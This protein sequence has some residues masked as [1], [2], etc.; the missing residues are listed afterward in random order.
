VNGDDPGS[1]S[2]PGPADWGK[3][4]KRP[5]GKKREAPRSNAAGNGW[6]KERAGRGGGGP[7]NVPRNRWK[8]LLQKMCRPRGRGKTAKEKLWG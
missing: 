1:G 2:E 8:Q 7:E 4:G 5:P 3:L 6:G